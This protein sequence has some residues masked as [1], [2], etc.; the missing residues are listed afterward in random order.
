MYVYN[1]LICGAHL[2]P[3]SDLGVVCTVE[4]ARSQTLSQEYK[5]TLGDKKTASKFE[6]ETIQ[7]Y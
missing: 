1:F 3:P 4:A 6:P 5:S 2:Q 7:K